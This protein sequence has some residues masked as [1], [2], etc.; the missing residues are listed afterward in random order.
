MRWLLVIAALC[1]SSHTFADQHVFHLNAQGEKDIGFAQAVRVGNTLYISGSVG[2]GEMPAAIHQAYEELKTTLAAFGL[3]FGDVV[4]ENVYATNIDEFI[5]N[6]AIR[7]DYYGKS[8]PASTWVEVRRLY[9]PDHVVEVELIAAIPHAK[10]SK[11][12]R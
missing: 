3:D 5:L 10:H 8:T 2:A 4:K 9:L 11:S 1:I 6:Q 12:K 7:K